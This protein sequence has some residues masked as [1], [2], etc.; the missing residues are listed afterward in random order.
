MKPDQ[1]I[2]LLKM[3]HI[4][5]ALWSFPA[6]KALRMSLPDATVDMLCTP[7]L[8][9]VYQGLEFLDHVICYDAGSPLA[10]RTKLLA[11]LRQNHYDTAIVL[12]PVDKVNHLAFLSGAAQRWGYAY[13]GNLLRGL[14]RHFFM[15][16]SRP[17]PA[18]IAAQTGLS[19]PHEVSTLLELVA[20]FTKQ[21]ASNSSLFFPLQEREKEAARQK[22]QGCRP[23]YKQYAALHLCAKSFRHGWTEDVFAGLAGQLQQLFPDTGWFITAGPAEQKYLPS[24]QSAL[25]RHNL[26]LI[27]GLNLQ[28]T[29]ALLAESRLLVSWDT[30]VVHL[31]TAVGT[32]VVDVF[33]A[34]DF[35][36]CV[37]RWGPWES[38]SQI[39]SQNEPLA[40]PETINAII[41]AVIRLTAGKQEENP[42]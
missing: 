25:S 40:G 35:A 8:G 42:L 6:I 4:G 19:L 39:V 12:G 21:Q 30:G 28:Q 41:Q 33:P 34:K 7:Y 29:A 23:G 18:D 3:D 16:W 37:Q 15:T 13:A 24:Y 27:G 32:P 31:A 26:P 11:R 22:L 14:T 5:D 1:H 9:E 20:N 38:N 36:Y 10:E 17:H 2:L